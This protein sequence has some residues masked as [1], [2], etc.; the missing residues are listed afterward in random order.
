MKAKLMALLLAAGLGVTGVAMTAQA[1]EAGTRE[2]DECAHDIIASNVI[3]ERA[4]PYDYR[5][6]ALCK[7]VKYYCSKCDGYE[8]EI[9]VGYEDHDYENVYDDLGH[10]ILSYCTACGG[11]Y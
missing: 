7:T 9:I 2:T 3:N 10:M 6:H 1:A 4:V 5:R 11:I 8:V